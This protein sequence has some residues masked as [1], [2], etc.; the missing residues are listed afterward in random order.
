MKRRSDSD[1]SNDSN[2]NNSISSS[3]SSA[4]SSVSSSSQISIRTKTRATNDKTDGGSDDAGG[5]FDPVF[6]GGCQVHFPYKKPYGVQSVFMHRVITAGKSRHRT[7]HTSLAITN[8]GIPKTIAT[9]RQHA[10][11]ESPTGTGKTMSLLCGSLAW[12]TKELTSLHQ[13]DNNTNNS[14]G[15]SSR[16]V[17]SKLD[18]ESSSSGS[19]T[20]SATT[21]TTTTTTSSSSDYISLKKQ[22]RNGSDDSSSSNQSQDTQDEEEVD[23][24]PRRTRV[25][26]G[27]RTH[28]QVK[29]A[30]GGIDI[31][32]LLIADTNVMTLLIVLIITYQNYKS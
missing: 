23:T 15:S 27:T 10:L 30:I 31:A 1:D 28:S 19:G 8:I 2:D 20:S 11:L 3:S 13:N 25:Y 5:D 16:G 9:Q 32:R 4:T 18:A 22:K 12:L 6:I 21:T 24:K 7:Q 14:N 17:S 29:Q 26:Y